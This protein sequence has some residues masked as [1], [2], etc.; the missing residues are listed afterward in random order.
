[1]EVAGIWDPWPSSGTRSPREAGLVLC[2]AKVFVPAWSTASLCWAPRTQ[3]SAW[4]LNAKCALIYLYIWSIMTLNVVHQNVES[5]SLIMLK[6]LP[7]ILSNFSNTSLY[8]AE[9][10]WYK[11]FKSIHIIL[12][13]LENS[14]VEKH[15][16]NPLSARHTPALPPSLWISIH[17]SRHHALLEAIRLEEHKYLWLNLK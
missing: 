9:I 2:K 12:S 17:L 6:F 3:K 13:K 8:Y 15:P 4:I 5:L 14:K 11:A 1:M 10:T 7:F 16:P